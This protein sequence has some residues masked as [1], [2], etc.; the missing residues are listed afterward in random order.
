MSAVTSVGTLT[1][2]TLNSAELAADTTY[3][4]RVG[5]LWNGTTNYANTTRASTSTL[6]SLLV[7]PQIFGGGTTSVTANPPATVSLLG[8]TVA[9]GA[10]VASLTSCPI[11]AAVSAGLS[12]TCAV[13]S[14]GAVK[15]R[16]RTWSGELGD[17][18]TAARAF[19]CGVVGLGW[20]G[21]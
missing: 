9:L 10:G 7:V 12:D 17:G 5:S 18:T 1:G 8:G 21:G 13:T 20:R 4:V 15:S 3:F 11:V 19:P 2:L 16:G 14:A 6:T